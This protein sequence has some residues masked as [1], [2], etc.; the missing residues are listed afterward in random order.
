MNLPDKFDD[1][2]LTHNDLID[3]GCVY[4]TAGEATSIN[5]SILQRI[6]EHLRV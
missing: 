2:T 4:C 5:S 6:S 1:H 3:L